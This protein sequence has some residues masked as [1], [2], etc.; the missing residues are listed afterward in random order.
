MAIRCIV[1]QEFY[2][3]VPDLLPGDCGINFGA[4]I[5]RLHAFELPGYQTAAHA[6]GEWIFASAVLQDGV[7]VIEGCNRRI[8]WRHE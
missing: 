3:D 2:D 1:L 5:V 8:G 4:A 6:L 7:A